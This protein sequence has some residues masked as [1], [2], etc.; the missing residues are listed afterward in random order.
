[1]GTSIP[2]HPFGKKLIVMAIKLGKYSF[3]GPIALSDK[4]RDKSGV[5]AILCNVDSEYFLI[6]VGESLKLRTRIENH[7]K[8]NCWIKNCNGQLLIYVHYTPF[9]KQQ[10]RINIEHELRELYQPDCKMDKK[11]VFQDDSSIA[12]YNIL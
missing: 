5:Y 4:I 8:K 9:L 11:I 10:A 3:A 7:D 12:F 6:D 1:M 2:G